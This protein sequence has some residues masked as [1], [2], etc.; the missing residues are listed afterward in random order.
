MPITVER[1][2]S[3][4]ATL[5][6]NPARILRYHVD[7]TNDNLLAEALIDAASPARY[8]GL[9]KQSI[10]F[11]P[12][13][14]PTFWYGDV[15]YG[16]KPQGKP[17]DVTW[18]FDIDGPTVHLSHALKHIQ[19]YA[20]DGA[21]PDHKGA[22]GVTDDREI[23]GC[24]IEGKAFQWTETHWLSFDQFTPAYINDLYELRSTVNKDAWRIWQPKEVLFR[25]VSGSACGEDTVQL[26]F[27]FAAEPNRVN[28][29]IGDIAGIVKKGW[30]YL[31][32]E[33][34]PD[35]D[36]AA[37]T[38]VMKPKAVHIEE[39]YEEGDFTKLGLP[40]PWN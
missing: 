13:E 36:A 24:D 39:V 38:I 32:V 10:K 34:K 30:E 11:R 40:D 17:G 18:Q 26:T 3:R 2:S 31:W 33:S 14:G 16:P 9:L 5:G 21:P 19:S 35:E 4:E 29:K 12:G 23:E 8:M 20:A 22:I 25:G 7:G 6:Q 28:L 15:V 27:R 1:L 37:K